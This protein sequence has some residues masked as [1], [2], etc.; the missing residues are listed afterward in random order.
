MGTFQGSFHT[1]NHN[2]LESLPSLSLPPPLTFSL[3]LSLSFFFLH[4]PNTS[5]FL[6]PLDLAQVRS[7]GPVDAPE[8]EMATHS[9]TLAWKI[10]WTEE[11]GRLQSMESQRVRHKWVTSLSFLS[12]NLCLFDFLS[13]FFFFFSINYWL[14][15]TYQLSLEYFFHFSQKLISSIHVT[16]APL[17][18]QDIH[19]NINLRYHTA[20]QHYIYYSVYIYTHT[21]TD[22]TLYIYIYQ[23]S[24]VTQSCP[25]LWD[26]TPPAH[27]TS[28]STTNSRSLLELIPIESVM[29]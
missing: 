11:P 1:I 9:S 27:Q 29:L 18:W 7:L 13:Y 5:Y 19:I 28:L 20:S 22:L 24:S 6:L 2:I 26:P 8:K 16:L 21:H 15:K 14:L 10:S 25:T 23:F 17:I 4:S 3:S 12:F